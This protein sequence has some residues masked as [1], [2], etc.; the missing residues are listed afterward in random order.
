MKVPHEYKCYKVD[1]HWRSSEKDLVKFIRAVDAVGGTYIMGPGG[2]Y[3]IVGDQ[4][5]EVGDIVRVR[6]AS[7]HSVIHRCRDSQF[8]ILRL[9]VG[10]TSIWGDSFQYRHECRDMESGEAIYLHN[11]QLEH[12]PPLEAIAGVAE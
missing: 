4:E 10:V 11:S 1:F 12:V 2:T 8:E 3:V 9:N 5:L 6:E 7:K